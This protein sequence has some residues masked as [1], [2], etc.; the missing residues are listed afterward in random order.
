MQVYNSTLKYMGNIRDEMRIIIIHR[1]YSISMS[2]LKCYIF[3]LSDVSYEVLHES[4]REKRNTTETLSEKIY[5]TTG[6]QVTL[7]PASK[8][9]TN[10]NYVLYMV[11]C[12]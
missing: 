10:V 4:S 7:L 9:Y 6:I 12:V 8:Q 5:S 1:R 2:D 11:Y 3:F